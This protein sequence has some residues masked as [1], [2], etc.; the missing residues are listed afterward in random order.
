MARR[1]RPAVGVSSPDLLS[2]PRP[3]RLGELL[4]PGRTAAHRRGLRAGFS[5]SPALTHCRGPLLECPGA[6][7]R[8]FHRCGAPLPCSCARP[9]GLC[10]LCEL[11]ART[12]AGPLNLRGGRALRPEF[13]ARTGRLD[14]RNA[15]CPYLRIGPLVLHRRRELRVHLGAC[16]RR[17]ALRPHIRT[18]P[19]C[20]RRYREFRANLRARHRCRVPRANFGACVPRA[21]LRARPRLPHRRRELRVI[22][23]D[24]PRHRELLAYLRPVHCGLYRRRKFC[25][26]LRP[27]HRGL[28]PRGVRRPRFWAGQRRLLCRRDPL[29]CPR[30]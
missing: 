14:C 3:R 21:N 22:A 30:A 20:L 28:Q 29:A 12:R 17:C 15:P 26:H 10:R 16:H 4:E 18:R 2:A 1:A 5:A 24:G 23:R 19:L 13:L 8:L 7:P 9:L 11:F 25:P 27:V 6:R